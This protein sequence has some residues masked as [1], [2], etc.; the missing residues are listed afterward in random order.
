M[1]I[2]RLQ[3]IFEGNRHNTVVQVLTEE[4]TRNSLKHKHEAFNGNEEEFFKRVIDVVFNRVRIS[5]HA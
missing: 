4:D 3:M 2:N 1:E 5:K